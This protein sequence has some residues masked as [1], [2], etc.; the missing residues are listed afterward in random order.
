MNFI[1]IQ[2]YHSVFR[3]FDTNCDN[4]ISVSEWCNGLSIFCRG[5]LDEKIKC[6]IYISRNLKNNKSFFL[7][8][9][10]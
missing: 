4:Y 8:N 2:Y 9:C 3:A 7:M 10:F 5:T 1:E 6:K